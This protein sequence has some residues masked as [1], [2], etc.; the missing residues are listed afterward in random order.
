ILS[1]APKIG[2][3][4]LNGSGVVGILSSTIKLRLNTPNL[5][6]PY[7]CSSV[8]DRRPSFNEVLPAS[9]TLIT[10]P[11]ASR[12]YQVVTPW[13]P[14]AGGGITTLLILLPLA[15]YVYDMTVPSFFTILLILP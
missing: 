14:P 3:V 1:P 6:L 8:C 5:L 15:S 7:K 4:I 10:F 11:C 13:P 9:Y 2:I 12:A